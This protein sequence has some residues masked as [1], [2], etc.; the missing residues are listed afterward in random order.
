MDLQLAGIRCPPLCYTGI[1]YPVQDRVNELSQ[2]KTCTANSVSDA[3][4][5]SCHQVNSKATYKNP[6]LI[7]CAGA[8]AYILHSNDIWAFVFVLGS[9]RRIPPYE[10]FILS[11][12]VVA[13]GDAMGSLHDMPILSLGAGTQNPLLSHTDQQVWPNG[14]WEQGG[15]E[16]H[17]HGDWGT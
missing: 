1:L 4:H 8:T 15:W 2:L 5:H 9:Y 7:I 12:P 13:I 16:Q 11:H 6:T 3:F 17:M 14:V 10:G